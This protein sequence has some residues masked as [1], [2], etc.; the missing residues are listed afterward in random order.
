MG[1]L[2]VS[3]GSY[4]AASMTSK[5]VL[6]PRPKDA[7]ERVH[8]FVRELLKGTLGGRIGGSLGLRLG[9]KSYDSGWP[10]LAPLGTSCFM[11]SK[12]WESYFMRRWVVIAAQSSHVSTASTRAAVSRRWDFS[13]GREGGEECRLTVRR[14]ETYDVKRCN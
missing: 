5:S 13:V 4:S 3:L 12:C 7:S 2:S 10:D 6:I 14:P 9:W 11:V 1:V 8:G